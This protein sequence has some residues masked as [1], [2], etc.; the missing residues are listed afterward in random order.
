MKNN[1]EIRKEFTTSEWS[2]GSTTELYIYPEDG[3]YKDRNFLFRI[4]S[5]V[6]RES[7]SVFTKLSG[8]TRTLTLLEGTLIL[9]HEGEPDITLL[10]GET[11]IF[12]GEKKTVSKGCAIDYNL[13]TKNGA[14]GTTEY[15]CL[16]Q[17]DRENFV[18]HTMDDSN[19]VALFYVYEGAILIGNG[20]EEQI[21]H[22]GELLIIKQSSGQELQSFVM[23]NRQEMN[24]KIIQTIVYV[25]E[26]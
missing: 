11:D 17:G 12:A 14:H 13:M 22:Q 3:N 8:V 18:I 20:Y 4:S 25:K 7:P 21:V 24:A 19:C 6:V 5:A 16:L 10:S 2:G 23:E 15:I 9:K 26:Q 1:F